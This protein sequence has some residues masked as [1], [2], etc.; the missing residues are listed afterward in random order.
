MSEKYFESDVD[1]GERPRDI[2]SR[3]ERR[4]PMSVPDRHNLKRKKVMEILPVVYS[5]RESTIMRTEIL[6]DDSG[7]ESHLEISATLGEE[8][9]RLLT[10]FTL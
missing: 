3:F 5:Q 7:L 8:E 1:A 10:D 6:L 4:I 2:D 9:K